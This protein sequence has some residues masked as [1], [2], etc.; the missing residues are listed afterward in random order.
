MLKQTRNALIYSDLAIFLLDTR[1]GITMQDI[2]LYNWLKIHKMRIQSDLDSLKLFK[3]ERSQRD[4]EGPTMDD[5]EE[6]V[7]IPSIVD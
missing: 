7:L 3:K 4:E 2:A 5:F 1:E 6:Q